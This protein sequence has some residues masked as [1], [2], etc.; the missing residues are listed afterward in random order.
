VKVSSRLALKSI[1]Q[2]NPSGFQ[3]KKFNHQDFEISL[4]GFNGAILEWF[5]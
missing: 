5:L 3:E 2:V 1:R 4:D